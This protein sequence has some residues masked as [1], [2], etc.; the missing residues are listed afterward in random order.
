MRNIISH[1]Y[2]K[3]DEEIIFETIREE[4][5]SDV[6]KFIKILNSLQLQ[7]KALEEATGIKPSNDVYDRV[8]NF[9][10]SKRKL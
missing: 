7:L 1:Q 2:G 3:V 6:R 4:L 10:K 5:D 9:L 8:I